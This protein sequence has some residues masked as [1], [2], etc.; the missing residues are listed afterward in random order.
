MESKFELTKFDV[1]MNDQDVAQKINW[2]LCC[3]NL[4]TPNIFVNCLEMRER[5]I[6]TFGPIEEKDI[7]GIAMG[8]VE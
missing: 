5:F 6:R 3:Y 4:R 1:F 2:G 7:P 8:Y